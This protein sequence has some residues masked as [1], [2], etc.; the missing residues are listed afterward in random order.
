MPGGAPASF[1]VL[2]RG[3]VAQTWNHASFWPADRDW[4]SRCNR[5]GDGEGP[6]PSCW[7]IVFGFGIHG[8][9]PMRTI[10]VEGSVA[11]FTPP[12]IM[13]GGLVGSRSA[14]PRDVGC[15]AGRWMT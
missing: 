6:P 7:W 5:I 10:A 9:P 11:S 15:R 4:P 14:P 2:R 3:A 8:R 1:Q 12:R 13:L